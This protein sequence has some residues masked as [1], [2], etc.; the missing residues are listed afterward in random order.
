MLHPPTGN[1]CFINAALQCLRYTPG[2]P[3][4]VAPDL[5]DLAQQ[6]LAAG[7]L[8]PAALLPQQ[9]PEAAP[10]T[11]PD[12]HELAMARASCE[13]PPEVAE[14]VR[15]ELSEA[16]ADE[17]SAADGAAT[18]APATAGAA[19][20]AEGAAP[21]SAEAEQPKQQEQQGEGASGE[22]SVDGK[23]QPQQLQ[24]HPL[25]PAPGA[26][27]ERPPKGAL[28]ESFAALVRALYLQ[29]PGSSP[30]AAV[31][32]APMLRTLRAFPIACAWRP[33]TAACLPASSH[34][35]LASPCPDFYFA[36]KADMLRPPSHSQPITLMAGSTIARRCCEW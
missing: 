2:L 11:E 8:P 25:A 17:A 22:A 15:R 21:E 31:C 12:V 7:D 27:A 5:A 18:D 6:R 1:T 9:A 34:A 28:L 23:G 29:A 24:P 36:T 30:D 3:L 35:S 14:A 33:R 19:A 4:Q 32:A 16:C 26:A 10:E 20:A 13:V